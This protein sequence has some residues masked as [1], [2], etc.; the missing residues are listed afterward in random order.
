MAGRI[1]RPQPPTLVAYSNIARRRNPRPQAISSCDAITA[2]VFSSFQL[3]R[4]RKLRLLGRPIHRDAARKR[5]FVAS[6]IF[7]F[8]SHSG[9]GVR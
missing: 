4:A 3:E 6:E 1:A 5:D 7:Y 2:T 9:F 8:G